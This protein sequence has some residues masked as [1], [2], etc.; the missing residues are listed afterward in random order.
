[1]QWAAKM[2][3]SG[4]WE[5]GLGV[6]GSFLDFIRARTA[7][8]GDGARPGGGDDDADGERD[9]SRL[10][11]EAWGADEEADADADADADAEAAE[12]SAER[13]EQRGDSGAEPVAA[14]DDGAAGGAFPMFQA[15]L[16]AKNAVV[17]SLLAEHAELRV[18]LHDCRC[19]AERGDEELRKVR[20]QYWEA[21]TANEDKERACDALRA[22]VQSGRDEIVRLSATVAEQSVSFA[23]KAEEFEALRA[24]FDAMQS[25]YAS[26]FSHE[27]EDPARTTPLRTEDPSKGRSDDDE[28]ED[29]FYSPL[30]NFA[31]PL[32]LRN[33]GGPPAAASPSEP[34][35]GGGLYM[36]SSRAMLEQQAKV[37]KRKEQEAER[38]ARKLNDQKIKT[39]R[40]QRD[41]DSLLSATA[42][43]ASRG[44][45]EDG[46][47]GLGSSGEEGF[48][49]A[50]GGEE[51]FDRLWTGA[52]SP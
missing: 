6:S 22:E 7:A 51:V 45:S 35:G 18:E 14:A 3:A 40:L 9:L 41:F 4:R 26:R 30:V 42:A 47:D 28:D 49:E 34:E 19:A 52:S 29:D 2:I 31:S 24:K 23:Q 16:A 8:G 25:M 1:M 43:G 38:L 13:G 10:F 37:I 27:N 44:G 11:A 50:A 39:E 36:N 15:A 20:G 48:L 17:E 33:G 32:L 21:V 5:G 46:G 12:P